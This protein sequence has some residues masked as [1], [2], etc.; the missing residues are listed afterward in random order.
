[1]LCLC[2]WLI[3]R[4][5]QVWPKSCVL[6][7]SSMVTSYGL[8]QKPCLGTIS[9][10][11]YQGFPCGS[12]GKESACNAGYLGS[13]PGLGRSPGEGKGFLLQYADPE[14]SMDYIVHGIT[15]SWR[16]LSNFHFHSAYK[17]EK[18][19]DNTQP[20]YIAFPIFNQS[21]VPCPVL[22][23]ASWP[24]YRFLKRQAFQI[25]F[26]DFSSEKIRKT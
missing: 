14:N 3:E 26:C 17:L 23:V 22:T 7:C 8:W 21:V 13:I 6:I 18:H 24:A 16:R 1:M 12:A 9:T 2:V 5:I 11:Q 25:Y 4:D 10:C 20:C 15:K 19:N